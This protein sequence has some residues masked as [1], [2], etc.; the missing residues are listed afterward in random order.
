M[1]TMKLAK[2]SETISCG[3]TVTVSKTKK[4]TPGFRQLNPG[5]FLLHTA[6]GTGD[7]Q[8]IGNTVVAPSSDRD[9]GL[10][11]TGVS[12]ARSTMNNCTIPN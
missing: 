10:N 9:V 7:S 11:N 3:A 6:V 2:L 12:R 8:P 4:E 1:L 5:A